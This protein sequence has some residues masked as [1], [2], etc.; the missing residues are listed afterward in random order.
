MPPL[1]VQFNRVDLS[2]GEIPP[3]N[4][5]INSQSTSNRQMAS[6][7]SDALVQLDGDI[8]EW[9]LPRLK[10]PKKGNPVSENL[11]EKVNV[12]C[13]SACEIDKI[14]SQY[15]VPQNCD[16]ARSPPDNHEIWRVLD[17][18]AQPQDKT[19]QDIQKLVATVMTPIIKLTE[20]IKPQISN[21]PEANTSLSD[22]LILLG[23]VQFHLSIRR[24]FY[25]RPNLR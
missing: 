2:D 15:K 12:V 25:I 19:I 17:S 4:N 23:Q 22:A 20:V 16:K 21:K 24:R 10:A 3:A 1:H 9:E 11:A 14:T 8:D 5:T 6:E 18:R 13:I 7:M